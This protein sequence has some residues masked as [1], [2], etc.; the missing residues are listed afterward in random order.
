MDVPGAGALEIG[1][2]DQE[3]GGEPSWYGWLITALAAFAQWRF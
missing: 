2:I 3:V 1:L